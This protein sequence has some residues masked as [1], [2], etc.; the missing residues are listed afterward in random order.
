METQKTQNICANSYL[1]DEQFTENILQ[2]QSTKQVPLPIISNMKPESIKKSD[3]KSVDSIQSENKKTRTD[4]TVLEKARDIC[5]ETENIKRNTAQLLGK[6]GKAS[7]KEVL[8]NQDK[9]NE[10]GIKIDKDVL[11]ANQTD[12][13]GFVKMMFEKGSK[14]ISNV[15]SNGEKDLVNQYGVKSKDFSIR[16]RGAELLRR[17]SEKIDINNIKEGDL[18][19]FK[20]IEKSKDNSKKDVLT[21]YATHVGIVSRVDKSDHNTTKIHFIHKSTNGGVIESSIEDKARINQNIYYKD[22]DP[23]FGR[24]R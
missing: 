16:F 4:N 12:C 19:F 20:N 23:T 21:D 8:S 2:P 22:L 15:I 17:G 3:N 6:N 1:Y 11:T 13:S 18:I 10:A 7:I 24:I 5:K 9:I 14:P